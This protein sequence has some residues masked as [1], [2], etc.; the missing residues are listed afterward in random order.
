[1]RIAIVCLVAAGLAGCALHRTYYND[2]GESVECRHVIMAFYDVAS[3]DEQMR[4]CERA[5]KAKGFDKL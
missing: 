5:A 3:T 2:K 4:E 1:L